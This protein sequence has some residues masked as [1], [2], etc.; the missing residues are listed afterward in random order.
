[1]IFLTSRGDRSLGDLERDCRRGFIK[2]GESGTF[3]C[4]LRLSGHDV[5]N[6][7]KAGFIFIFAK[8]QTGKYVMRSIRI[9]Q[10]PT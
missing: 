7:N 9:T 10:P 8:R 6:A 5:S 4:A 1:M 2:K 3:Y